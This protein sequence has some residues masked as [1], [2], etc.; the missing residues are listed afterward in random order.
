MENSV[1]GG[2]VEDGFFVRDENYLN[3]VL[4]GKMG[5]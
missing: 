3:V 2:D 4:R 1:I 5:R